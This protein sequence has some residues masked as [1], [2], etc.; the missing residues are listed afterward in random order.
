MIDTMTILQP[1]ASGLGE[2]SDGWNE[3][4]EE[5]SLSASDSGVWSE[6]EQEPQ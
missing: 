3:G 6:L 4:E 1:A 5:E 2:K